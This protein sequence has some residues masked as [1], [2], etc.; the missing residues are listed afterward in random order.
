[1]L[2]PVNWHDLIVAFILEHRLMLLDIVV[3]VRLYSLVL[4][5]LRISFS[6]LM[7]YQLV[8]RI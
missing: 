6:V 5:F 2:I 1:M 7:N 8:I 4:V 3:R